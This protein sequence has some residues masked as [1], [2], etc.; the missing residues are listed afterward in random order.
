MKA[1]IREN[2]LLIGAVALPLIVILFYVGATLVPRY[3]VAPPQHDLVVEYQPTYYDYNN[4]VAQ[5]VPSRVAIIVVEG[6]ARAVVTEVPPDDDARRVQPTFFL[7]RLFR[8]HAGT[9]RITELD[10]PVPEDLAA[11]AKGSEWAIPALDAVRLSPNRTAPDGYVF[12]AD[13]DRH[14]GLAVELFGGRSR[15]LGARIAMRG[16]VIKIPGP[17][18]V[19]QGGYYAYRLQFVGW[20]IQ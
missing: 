1:F 18:D 10:V 12:D 9:G 20:V 13:D 15:P 8:Y 4:G 11:R 16:R 3:L 14:R 7:P 5:M 19:P 6:R 2:R 17:D